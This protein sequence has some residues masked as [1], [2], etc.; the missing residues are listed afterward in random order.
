MRA[1][2]WLKEQSRCEGTGW[3]VL[4]IHGLPAHGIAFGNFS[5]GD[6][7]GQLFEWLLKATEDGDI[8]VEDVADAVN[9][10]YSQT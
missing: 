9:Y 7:E 5:V 1:R 3:S 10:I 4:E 2:E 6:T 8:D